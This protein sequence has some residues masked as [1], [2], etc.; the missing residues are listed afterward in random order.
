MPLADRRLARSYVHLPGYQERVTGP[1]R[2][3]GISLGAGSFASAW[4]AQDHGSGRLLCMKDIDRRKMVEEESEDVVATELEVYRHMASWEKECDGRA[5]LMQLEMCF[6]THD[7]IY[8]VMDLMVFDLRK[9]MADEPEFSFENA[10]RL[11]A[12]MAL[13]IN[14]LHS[15]GIIHRDIK[16][17]N[18]LI[19]SRYNVKIA[20]FGLSHLHGTPLEP[21]EGYTSAYMGTLAY[22]APE[23]MFN[24]GDK[25]GCAVDWWSFGC[26]LYEL[27]SPGH[28]AGGL[29]NAVDEI[30]AY[31]KSSTSEA[32]EELDPCLL[33]PVDCLRYE[34]EGIKSHPWFTVNGMSEFDNAAYRAI[35]RFQI[36][37]IHGE[38]QDEHDEEL[39]HPVR[40]EWQ[41]FW[42][43][44][45]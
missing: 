8:F 31:V 2:P 13:G 35:Q 28:K 3:L 15:M 19:D 36:K 7:S 21:G 6:S 26:V 17:D 42:P 22:M 40:V 44:F 37:F 27:I 39:L 5:F 38:D 33:E 11:S 14:A 12:Q 10:P 9:L 29:F 43:V 24:E 16:P 23:V 30:D 34:F 20:D 45:A 4:G 25:Y 1:F 32:L 41:N 18:I